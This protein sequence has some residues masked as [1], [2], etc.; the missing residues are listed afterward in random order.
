MQSLDLVKCYQKHKED[1]KRQKGVKGL[2][3]KLM[4][5]TNFKGLFGV[6]LWKAPGF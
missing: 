4:C 6:F 3:P 2:L 5:I 1:V